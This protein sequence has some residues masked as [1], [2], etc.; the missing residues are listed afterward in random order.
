V[1]KLNIQETLINYIYT[2]MENATPIFQLQKLPGGTTFD[3]NMNATMPESRKEPIEMVSYSDV[4]KN[5]S[6]EVH[7]PMS[8]S[9]HSSSAMTMA[10]DS[11][12]QRGHHQDE[13]LTRTKNFNPNHG[14]I[15]D[16]VQYQPHDSHHHQVEQ[17]MYE[18]QHQHQNQQHH[19]QY[20]NDGNQ[21][22]RDKYIDNNG[23]RRRT[24]I[25]ENI[26]QSR[27]DF[28]NE[29]IVLLIIYVIIHTPYVQNLLKRKMPFIINET[30]GATGIIGTVINGALLIVLWT[31]SKRVVL[32]Y[33]K[34][35]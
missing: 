3:N 5:M 2:R 6:T 31:I 1:F 35:L 30:T 13:Q 26:T 24:I 27:P 8:T 19:T 4:L 23:S 20:D 12:Q 7:P 21:N 14:M 18:D 9:I 17:H 11:Q 32:K 22:Q 29:M 25:E 33:M 16:P 15:A 28:Q 34:D 10:M